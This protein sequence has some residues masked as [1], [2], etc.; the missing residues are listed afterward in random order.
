MTEVQLK[1]D[2]GVEE[3]LVHSKLTL[4]RDRDEPLRLDGEDVE[5]RAARLDGRALVPADYT[6]DVA[7]LTIPGA[8]DGSVLELEV[9]IHPAGNSQLCGLYPSGT[10]ERGFLLTQCEAQGFRRITFFPD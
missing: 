4:A 8:R 9:R 5:L 6:L 7:G 2:L 3:T 10:P 1:F